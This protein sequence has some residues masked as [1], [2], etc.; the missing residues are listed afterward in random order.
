MPRPLAP[1]VPSRLCVVSDMHASSEKSSRAPVSEISSMLA[2]G[3]CGVRTI[4]PPA[5]ATEGGV[6]HDE[7]LVVDATCARVVPHLACMK[8]R[9][10]ILIVARTI[11]VDFAE[12]CACQWVRCVVACTPV[13]WDDLE[14]ALARLIALDGGPVSS[15]SAGA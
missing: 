5:L 11:D 13:S 3:G 12:L 7:I 4:A 8:Q 15:A 14:R 9:P 2:R 10:P 6:A 1:A